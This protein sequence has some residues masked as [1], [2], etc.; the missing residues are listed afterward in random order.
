RLPAARA[1]RRLAC[2]RAGIARAGGRILGMNR[3]MALAGLAAVA[4]ATA[5]GFALAQEEAIAACRAAPSDA[6]RIACLE[7]ALRAASSGLRIPIPFVGGRS[8]G[9]GPASQ[10]R[11]SGP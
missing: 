11:P 10:P 2:N 9:D 1:A 6:E 8:G 7:D 3:V 4:A 5:P